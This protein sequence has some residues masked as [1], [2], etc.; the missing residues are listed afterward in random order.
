MRRDRRAKI[1]ATLGPASSDP[2][3]I[4][5]LFIAGVDI[6]RLNFS[7]GSHEDHAQRHR[8]IRAL[9]REVERP[10]AILQDLQGPKIRVGT[11]TGGRIMLA[12]AT[13]VRF[14]LDS[15]PGTAERI[16][17][18]HPEVFK[19]ILPGEKVYINDGRV[20]LTVTG[21]DADYFDAVVVVGGEVSDRKG[22]N[23]PD[24]LLDLSPITEKDHDDLRFG[25]KLGVDWVALSF[26]QT[27][28]DVID[29]RRL[30]GTDSG[31]M[32]KIEKPAALARFSEILQQAD[33]I[34]VARGDLGV[35]I[36][37]ED[38]PGWQKEIVRQ[39]RTAGKPVVVATQ[40]L[41][42]MVAS[43][44]PTR[45][46]ASDVATAVYDGADA[47]MLSA[48]SASGQ[49]PVEA[50]SMMD[51]IIRRTETH[52]SYQ[53]TIH[54]LTLELDPTV[55]HTVAASAAD[56]ASIIDAAVIVAFTASGNTAARVARKRP[57]VPIIAL[58]PDG[59][60]ARQ[61]S[62]M[63]GVHSIESSDV[64]N[65][66]EMLDRA[67]SHATAAEFAKP[68]DNIVVVAGMPFGEAGTTNNIRVLRVPFAAG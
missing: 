12:P 1:I 63:W 68:G 58:T 28:T 40:M 49:Y 16:P 32:V 4:R 15:G 2:D 60:V 13:T 66:Q 61:L 9:A 26:V 65:F 29:A 57:A 54:A 48:E 39:C 31:L 51:R 18:P 37:A 14:V 24:T 21:C 22:I 44:T 62:L 5:A 27:P 19:G 10:I 17:L 11:F 56:I 55:A 45:A 36:P 25:Q 38:V 6:F 53:A 20:R 41:E 7:H 52:S 8:F 33:S 34:M 42:S 43:P 35:E 64:A 59:A 50:V 30:I 47:V 3:L 23:L 67:A 46:E